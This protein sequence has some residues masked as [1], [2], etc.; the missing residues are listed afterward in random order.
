MEKFFKKLQ[1]VRENPSIKKKI[2]FTLGMLALYRLLVFVPVPFVDVTELMARTI[3]TGDSGIGY[4]LMLL[5]GSLDQFAIIAIGLAP[6]INASIIMQL[7]G[8]VVPKLEELTEQGEAWQQ[9]IQQYT[10]YLMVPLAFAQSI[11]MVFFINHLLWGNVI[12]TDIGTLLLS[13]FVMTVGSVLLVWI[14]ELITEKWISNGISLLIFASIVAGMTQQVYASV[15]WTDNVIW[16]ILFMLVLV[17]WLVLLSIFILKSMKEIPVIYARRGRVEE[18]S[19]LPIPLNPVWMIPIIFSIAFVSFPYLLSKL[20]V[21]FQPMNQK[22]V[23]MANWIELNMNIYT[24]QPW[25]V[26]II[27]Y[28]V[29]I[30]AFTFFY[31]LIVFSPEKISDNIQKRGGFV[32]GI[33]PGKETA[34]Y[35]NGI[36]MHL[37]LWWWVGLALIWV[38]TYLLN[39][40]PFIQTL[41]QTLGSLPVVVAGSGV[42]IIVWVVQEIMN[43]VKTDL[44]MQRYDTIDLHTVNKNINK[45]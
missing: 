6:F 44:L 13:A 21:Q 9:K 2:L 43:K 4:F 8:S 39:Y 28:F 19:S 12:P 29:L 45:L 35:I 37:C 31:T 40:I 11:G 17:L 20:L 25:L 27:L 14:G 30:V 15:A 34:N 3:S 5:W 42:I 24:Q 22:F 18:S 36:L 1:E 16:L 7:L 33:R 32:P 23:A 26:A 41:V 10:R 38:Y